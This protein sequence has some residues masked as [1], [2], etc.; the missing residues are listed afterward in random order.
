MSTV[1]ATHVQNLHL[2]FHISDQMLFGCHLPMRTADFDTASLILTNHKDNLAII[3][4][5]ELSESTC[6]REKEDM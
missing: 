6:K 5:P 3:K 4:L 1:L 2:T